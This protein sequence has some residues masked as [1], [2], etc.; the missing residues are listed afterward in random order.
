MSEDLSSSE[1]TVEETV[2]SEPTEPVQPEPI[3]PPKGGK[4]KLWV[5]VVAIIVVAALVG[6]A[7][8]M[9]VISKGLE[10]SLSPDEIPNV[11]AGDLLSLSVETK[12]GNK[13]VTGGDGVEY[14]W[15][16]TPATVGKVEPQSKADVVFTAGKAAGEG[17]I[18]CEVT[19]NGKTETVEATIIVDPPYLEIVNVMPSEKTIPPGDEWDFTASSVDSVGDIIDNAEVGYVWSVSGGAV[20][21]YTL[22]PT[23]GPTVSFS[24]SVEKVY[25]LTA[26]ATM[27]TE[28]ASGTAIADVTSEVAPRTI[29][30]YWYGMFEHELGPW[31]ETRDE[32][33]DG[34]EYALTDEV[35]YLYLWDVGQGNIWIY[36]HVR[37]NATG[38]N[39]PDLNMNE[40]P[41]FLPYFGTARGGNAEVNWYMNYATY[42][43]CEGKLGPGSLS[44]YD[45]WF[46]E[47]NGTMTLDT[48]AAMAVLGATPDDLEDEAA[49]DSWW[50]SNGDSIATDWEAWMI[51]EAGND[52]L[53]IFAAYEYHLEIH[54]FVMEAEMVGDE[55]VL[56]MDTISWGMEVLV[57]RWLHEAV[58]PTEWY[59]EDMNLNVR[60]GPET[61]DLDLDAAVQYAAYA[62]ESTDVDAPCWCW[63]SLM[64][65]CYESTLANPI[66]LFDAYADFTYE[67]FAPGSGFYGDEMPFDYTPGI[68]NLT[69]GE[70]LTLEWP[71]FEVPFFI[72][73][74]TSMDGLVPRTVRIDA[75]MT[76]TYAEPDPVDAPDCC[77]ID[78]ENNTISYVGPFDM[79]TWQKD[80]TAHDALAEQWIDMNMP[81]YGAPYVEFRA[82]TDVPTYDLVLEG[83][84]SPLEIGEE[85]SFNVT[86]V[87]EMTRDPYTSY[88]GTVTFSSSD[89][90]AVLPDDYTFVAGDAGTH[91]FT[92][93]FNTVDDE[94][95]QSTHYVTA[96]DEVLDIADTQSD[97][98]VVESP[99][100][101]Y[102]DVEVA[103]GDVIAEEPVD[104]TVTAYNQW[105]EVFTDYDGTVNFTS[106]DTG[107]DLPPDT[108]ITTATGVQVFS[109]TFS[110]ED[111][112]ELNVSDV[113]APEAYGVASVDV[114]A[115]REIDHFVLS[116][117]DDPTNIDVAPSQTMTVTAYDQYGDEFTGYEGTVAFES[118]ESVGI[119]LP[120]NTAFTLGVSTID[121]D[122]TFSAVEFYT[123]WCND[124]ADSSITGSLKVNTTDIPIVLAGFVVTGVVD[125][126]ENNYSDI[127]VRAINNF[128][129]TFEEY[130]GTINFTTNAPVGS[131]TLPEDY[132]FELADNGVHTFPLGVSF[133]EPGTFNVTVADISDLTKNGSQEDIDIENLVATRLDIT[134]SPTT[135]IENV[136]FSM[137]VTVYH[138]HDEV[139]KEYDGIV[140]FTTSD[141][142]GYAELPT[143]YEFVPAADAGERNFPDELK[144]AEVGSQTVTVEDTVDS[145]LTDTLDIEVTAEITSSITY[146]VYDMF[147]Q[148]FYEF[149]EKRWAG[150]GTDV[151]LTTDDGN[152]TMLYF[153]FGTPSGDPDDYDQTMIYAPYRWNIT[154]EMLPN[155]NVHEPEF[156]PV[157]GAGPVTGAEASIYVYFNYLTA[158][159]WN[160]YWVAE[161]GSHPDWSRLSSQY[162]FDDG[163]T[164]GTY[165]NVSMNRLAAEEWIGLDRTEADVSSW[166]A[167]NRNAYET[168][169]E[170]FILDEANDRLDIW[171]GYEDRYWFNGLIIELYEAGPDEVYM[172][173]AHFSWGYEALMCRWLNE[174]GIST[175]QPWFEDF[176]MV[177]DYGEDDI[178]IEMDAV[179]QWA[180]HCNKANESGLATGAPCAWVWEPLKLDYVPSSAASGP[181]LS[182]YDPYEFLTYQ[183]WNCGDCRYGATDPLYYD[184]YEA[185]PNNFSLPDYGTLVFELPADRDDVLGY[186]GEPVDPLDS[187]EAWMWMDGMAG[188]DIDAYEALQYRGSVDLGWHNLGAAD[189]AYDAG[190]N[191]L[192]INGPF[193]WYDWRDEGAGALWHGSPWIEFNVTEVTMAAAASGVSGMPLEEPVPSSASSPATSGAAAT[194]EMLSL[195]SVACAVLVMVVGLAA[196]AV[197]RPEPQ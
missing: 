189:Y 62:Y 139:F 121:V 115:A 194:T 2:S 111:T 97:I 96:L 43:E 80:Q 104:V 83:I 75:E 1:S 152:A 33:Y 99:R 154:G 72:H 7:A 6:S 32:Y 143:P 100:I 88:T 84:G 149:W 24:A 15:E 195:V 13:V 59:M 30:Y 11:P 150:Y 166:W 110:A 146:K 116:G 35:P 169:W 23:T 188:G 95:H 76:C 119:V 69:E 183:G 123:I 38:V 164:L 106:N 92:V 136:S 55:I 193:D 52:R 81:P 74:E 90:A 151:L 68:W 192:T 14:W 44:S 190:A 102:F 93:T 129:T 109:V 168:D 127:T 163:Y 179:C 82:D 157:L 138:Q 94:T 145:S 34:E 105:D 101:A 31:Y 71:D 165:Y 58:M 130:V 177:V 56:T 159:W 153:P 39:M 78:L 144:L 120:P 134:G 141:A 70:T 182:E 28:T 8:Y 142:S 131:D 147:E 140:G 5:A 87:N 48:Q 113:A 60:I 185:A 187:I 137:Y 176:E 174:T 3:A 184:T 91:E 172:E 57:T 135:I 162:D 66:S 124:S 40:N 112:W 22:S 117:V 20:G 133:D 114:L 36:T 49:F 26:T 197:R 79:Y 161:W 180:M 50:A 107:A 128:D 160:D 9:L 171:C 132:T 85:S 98:L 167:S 178:D 73:D 77:T 27:G 173:I 10:V 29:D 46:V 191:V 118:N 16:F 21:E 64:Q 17:T 89:P 148:P 61:A 65:D 19:Y 37:L 170:N 18:K 125:M 12:W 25:T 181:H 4:K 122:L 103:S 156:M 42:E 175:H 53:A 108:Q 186:Y 63:E 41:E 126:W 67:N 45:G 196:G 54:Y 51:Y 158:E 86:I 47:M 155:A